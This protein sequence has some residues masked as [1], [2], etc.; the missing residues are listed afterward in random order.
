MPN[1]L[2]VISLIVITI[3]VA[4]NN[5]LV[6]HTFAEIFSVVIAF[7]IFTFG[8]RLRKELNNGYILFISIGFFFIALLDTI[9][10]I[11]YKGMNIFEH[12]GTNLATELWI[13]ARY[14][15]AFTMLFA[16]F[17]INI[18]VNPYKIF[19]FYFISTTTF[20]L[21]IFTF[22]VFP[23]CYVE[24]VGLTTFKIVSEYIIST[25][26]LISIIMLNRRQEFFEPNVL[27]LIQYGILITLVSELAF[28]LYISVYST[29]NFIGHIL[30]I[31]SFYFMYEALVYYG[32]KNPLT[33]FTKEINE[34]KEYEKELK[35][36][37]SYL[38]TILNTIDNIVIVSIAGERLDKANKSFLDFF[39]F[40]T[41]DEFKKYHTCVCECFEKIEDD[42]EYI[43]ENKDNMNWLSYIYKYPEKTHKALI[44]KNN[45]NYIFSIRANLMS[46]DELN[47]SII[48]LNDITELENY[49]KYLESRVNEEIKKQ[50][51]KDEL[52]IQQ[53]KMALMG[54][55]IGAIAH[56]WRQPLN[57]LGLII[58]EIEF[59]YEDGEV[60]K[61]EDLT[62]M[63]NK[64]MNQIEFMSKTIDDFRNFFKPN[65]EKGL[66]YADIPTKNALSIIN[67]QLKNNSINI[68]LK[69]KDNFQIDGYLGEFQQVILNLISNSKDAII[70]KRKKLEIAEFEGEISIEIY[71]I[72]NKGVI[73]IVDNGGGID[74]KVII[75]IF[76]PYFTT[77]AQG[78]GTGIGLYMS[79][80]IIEKNM[81]GEI[82]VENKNDGVSFEINFCLNNDDI[83]IVCN[84]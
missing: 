12:G 13:A 57:A 19:I 64:G 29:S 6:F 74:E 56:Q 28:T 77:K 35:Y 83:T 55:M 30:K 32:L 70:G 52:L 10:T 36:N 11:A 80:M 53:S 16:L 46:S 37:Q 34:R 49:K 79:K 69:V 26:L 21:L 3:L 82:I 73:K 25:I 72:N 31:I 20:I 44:I 78:E 71:K 39:E 43:Y 68:N 67:A 24:G 47:R 65:K 58:Q 51:Q 81:K 62:N 23:T 61:G 40:E 59:M 14:T 75:R 66:F 45:K 48:V 76:E 54:E 22:N 15:E 38:N 8:W 17:F 5:Y 33:L 1:V 7:A 84:S 4:S 50:K 18:Q 27:K 63:V 60:I 41:I 9:H 42:D 2:M